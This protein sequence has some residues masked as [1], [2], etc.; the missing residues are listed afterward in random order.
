M[1]TI[2]FSI[3]YTGR[4]S[5]IVAPDAS[6]LR[7][8]MR[9][10]NVFMAFIGQTGIPKFRAKPDQAADLEAPLEIDFF[11]LFG[12]FVLSSLQQQNHRSIHISQTIAQDKH[13]KKSDHRPYLVAGKKCQDI[14][15]VHELW[16]RWSF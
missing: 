5:S 4:R 1:A 9:P 11:S 8:D 16:V 12:K 14:P 13:N 6:G 3:I 10:S 2:V 15:N 7:M